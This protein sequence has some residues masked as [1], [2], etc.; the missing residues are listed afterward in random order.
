MIE[1]KI[2]LQ[3]KKLIIEIVLEYLLAL[4]MFSLFPYIL[5][6]MSDTM[7]G[8]NTGLDSIGQALGVVIILRF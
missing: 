6:Y 1:Q 2:K 7:I 8:D 3:K 5:L 4:F